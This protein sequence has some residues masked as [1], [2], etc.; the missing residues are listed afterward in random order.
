VGRKTKIVHESETFEFQT[1]RVRDPKKRGKGH[2]R[3]RVSCRW[4]FVDDFEMKR[5]RDTID[6]NRNIGGADGNAWVFKDKLTAEKNYMM[7]IAGWG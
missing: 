4:W 2:L 6:P 3:Y 7:L 1:I 5:I